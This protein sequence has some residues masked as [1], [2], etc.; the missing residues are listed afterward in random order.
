MSGPDDRLPGELTPEEHKKQLERCRYKVWL[1]VGAHDPNKADDAGKCW[2][3][4][5]YRENRPCHR[6]ARWADGFGAA[7]RARQ[8]RPYRDLREEADDLG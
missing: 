2:Q 3:G 7:Y 4:V 1:A 6:V 5:N 8:G